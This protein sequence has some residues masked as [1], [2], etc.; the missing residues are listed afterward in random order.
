[1]RPEDPDVGAQSEG[2]LFESPSRLARGLVTAVLRIIQWLFVIVTWT[3]WAVFGT[4][5]WF[6]LVFRVLAVY[7]ATFL[8]A[9]FT[10]QTPMA[11]EQRLRFVTNLWFDGFRN[12]YASVFGKRDAPP[13]ALKHSQLLLEISWSMFFWAGNLLLLSLQ[14]TQRAFLLIAVAIGASAFVVG[15]FLGTWKGDPIL[16]LLRLAPRD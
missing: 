3:F 16:R 15:L 8:Y 2:T 13:L 4:T 1:M 9:M 12:A 7:S 5:F 6:A 14:S 10:Y 11:I